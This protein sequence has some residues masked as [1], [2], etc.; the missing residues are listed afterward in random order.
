MHRNYICFRLVKL[1]IVYLI[2]TLTDILEYFDRVSH[3]SQHHVTQAAEV[4][5]QKD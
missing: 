5:M 3:Q 4:H 2:R 1:D